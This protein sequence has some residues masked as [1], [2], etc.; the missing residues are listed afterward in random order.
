M[1]SGMFGCFI[2]IIY[3][4]KDYLLVLGGVAVAC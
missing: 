1:H 2:R 3:Y 4:Y